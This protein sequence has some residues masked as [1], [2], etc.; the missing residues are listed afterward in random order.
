MPH[1]AFTN[2]DRLTAFDDSDKA[3]RN[4]E[5]VL[6]AL[7]AFTYKS[8]DYLE[9]EFF[10][11]VS[12][13]AVRSTL[14]EKLSAASEWIYAE[15]QDA[16]YK[17]LKSKLKE[18]EDIVKPILLRKSD[19]VERPEAFKKF[20]ANLADVKTAIDLV[21]LQIS[22]Q[23]AALSK[24][25][26][27]ASKASASSTASPSSSADSLDDLE[28]DPHASS[29]ESA[30]ATE[31]TEV[32]II[33]TEDDLTYVQETYDNASK[34]L[35]EKQ[36]AQKKLKDSDDPA[37]SV[38]DIKAESEK[39]SNAVVQIM[40][41]KSRIYNAPKPKKPAAKKPKKDSK[42]SKK[43]AK[44]GNG[45]S[46]QELEEA[47]EK[48]GLKKDSIKFANFDQEILDQDGKLRTKLDL[49]E[50][51]SEDEINEAIKK[52]VADAQGEKKPHDEL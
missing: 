23:E 6:N 13:D 43:A 10:T 37:V 8:R 3:R 25:A 36:A 15:G 20:E 51:A 40:M 47:L 34:W 16:D 12:T 35:E 45:L 33:Y 9:D 32:P 18:L 7:E 21:K 46:Q 41:K 52:V 19:S 38:K 49:P 48:A 2:K 24:S 44:D 50:G 31:P 26:E 28:E 5:E 39:L 29:S 27:A 14:E 4:R 22:D 42:K 11:A 1:L 17:T 30:A